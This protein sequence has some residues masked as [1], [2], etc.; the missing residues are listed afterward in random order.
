MGV[1]TRLGLQYDNF[2]IYTHPVNSKQNDTFSKFKAARP[3][4]FAFIYGEYVQITDHRSPS[5]LPMREGVGGNIE[6]GDVNQT[7]YKTT[8]V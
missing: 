7:V 1:N 5:R 6:Q 4:T 3:S 8:K 2:C